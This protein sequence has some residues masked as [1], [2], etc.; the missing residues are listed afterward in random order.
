LRLLYIVVDDL[1]PTAD[2]LKRL[3]AG[4]QAA[5]GAGS[6]FTVEPIDIGP[7]RYYENA[8]GLAMCV[9]GIVLKII[10]RQREFD[11]ALLGCW[12]DPG[13]RAARA[14]GDIPVIGAA[15][16]SVAL[17][18]LTGQRFGIVTI[19]SSDIP[20]IEAYVVGLQAMERCVGVKAVELPFYALVDDPAETLRR[21]VEQSRP[22]IEGGAQ[23]VLLGCMSFG[24]YPF[25]T[26]LQ[27]VLGI[28]V[29]DPLRAGVAA[30]QAAVSMGV[31]AS[32]RAVGRIEEMGPLVEWLN[33]VR[34]GLRERSPSPAGR[35]S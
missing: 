11:A 19:E 17:A 25:A 35:P 16:A 15:E 32:P 5:V 21:L 28:P 3:T 34:A 8:I 6:T 7:R 4:G 10:E 29:I 2:E 30:A 22:L 13:L 9:P 27:E 1:E 24:F 31:T 12:G 18:S 26:R 14:V 33:A 23:A 20:E